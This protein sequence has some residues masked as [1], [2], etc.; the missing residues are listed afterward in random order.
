MP[1][2]EHTMRC[3]YCKH[4]MKHKSCGSLSF[5]LKGHR[6]HSRNNVKIYCEDFE[7]R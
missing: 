6:K 5:C 7:E 4:L 2:P 1:R 3:K